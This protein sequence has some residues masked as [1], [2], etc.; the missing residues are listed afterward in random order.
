[1]D[2]MRMKKLGIACYGWI[3]YDDD[4]LVVVEIFRVR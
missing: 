1:M 2:G 3:V 4:V